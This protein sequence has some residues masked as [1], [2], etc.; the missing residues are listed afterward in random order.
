MASYGKKLSGLC[1]A[2]VLCVI[3]AGSVQASPSIGPDE[4][5]QYRMNEQNNPVYNSEYS[6]EFDQY[7]ETDG[8]VRSTP[9]VIGNK[10]FIGNH[11]TGTLQA[12]NLVIE[13]QNWETSAPNWVHSEMIYNDEQLFVGYGNR[14][15]QSSELRGTG[16]SGVM[17]VDSKTGETLWQFSTD[18]TVMPTP[19]YDD[20]RDALY[21]VTGGAMLYALDPGTGEEK[22]SID[23]GYRSSMSSPVLSDGM[24]YVGGVSGDREYA[25]LGIDVESQEVAWTTPFENV[26]AGLD[27]VPPVIHDGKVI[28]T[29]VEGSEDVRTLKESYD[30]NGAPDV[31]QNIWSRVFPGQAGKYPVEKYNH[32]AYAMDMESGEFV[33][34]NSLGD[35]EMVKNN[36]SGAPMIYEDHV[37]VASPITQEFY[38][39]DAESG[40]KAWTF[41]ANAAKAPPVAED[42][43]VYFA[44][45]EGFVFAIHTDSGEVE[46]ERWIGD[47]L[48]PSGPLLMNDHLIAGSQDGNVYAVLK[49]DILENDVAFPKEGSSYLSYLVTVFVLPVALFVIAISIG[50]YL[51]RRIIRTERG[52]PLKE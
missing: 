5:H 33:W 25:F 7:I 30:K 11:G 1:L 42:G 28:T 39:L 36:K 15:F 23:L 26:E 21:V 16:E 17:S 45:T 44:D 34:E 41:E 20:E 22:W 50:V 38:S 19:V 32:K 51:V 2:F 12:Y 8:E 3:G 46:G 24:L 48:A 43:I 52:L 10:I 49:E 47:T 40:E 9:V 14:M 37:Y 18:G 29:A 31:Y 35:G 4:W 27:D 6:K 13:N